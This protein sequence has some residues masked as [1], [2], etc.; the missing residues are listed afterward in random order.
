MMLANTNKSAMTI[1][2]PKRK[3]LEEGPLVV[4]YYIVPKA[5]DLWVAHG[6]ALRGVPA[7]SRRDPHPEF[8][9]SGDTEQNAMR[10][11]L[12]ELENYLDE[13]FWNKLPCH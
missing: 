4:E 2:D 6:V 11:M 8:T 7:D 13:P 9:G 12:R 1:A 3:L 10:A 5:P